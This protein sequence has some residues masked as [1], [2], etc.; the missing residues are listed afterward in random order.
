MKKL[1]DNKLDDRRQSLSPTSL[2]G[3]KPCHRICIEKSPSGIRAA[4]C[5]LNCSAEVSETGLSYLWYLYSDRILVL[6]QTQHVGYNLNKSNVATAWIPEILQ[7]SLCA[8]ILSVQSPKC[9]IRLNSKTENHK[10]YSVM[11]AKSTVIFF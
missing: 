6:P 1:E 10:I 3:K 11:S 8:G 5:T 9:A 2:A 7:H 4:T